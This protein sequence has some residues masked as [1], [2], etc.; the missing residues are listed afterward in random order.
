L[1]KEKRN[2]NCEEGYGQEGGEEAG[3]KEGSGEKGRGEKGSGQEGRCEE[4][5]GEK[6]RGEE[7][8]CKEGRQ[9]K[10]SCEKSGEEEGPC[11]KGCRQEGCEKTC[12]EES[13][14]EAG[15]K[16]GCGSGPGCDFDSNKD[17][18]QPTSC[19]A[20]PDGREALIGSIKTG[21]RLRPGF[22][23]AFSAVA[24][25]SGKPRPRLHTMGPAARV[26]LK[27][28]PR[29]LADPKPLVIRNLEMPPSRALF[30]SQLRSLPLVGR[31][32]VRDI[33]AV[34]S[35]RLLLVAS[36]RLSAFDV[37]MAEPIPGKGEV[38]TQTALFWF[39]RLAD[40]EPLDG[41][42]PGERRGRG[43]A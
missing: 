9:E 17:F 31:G 5:S 16:E 28:G 24:L 25:T 37:V 34:G 3:G 30:E 18:A 36:D 4:G 22:L 38:L 29:A 32:K 14:E 21:T 10:G 35:D 39:A 41:A 7:A 40:L 1:I 43:G 2:G 42:G 6:G 23:L 8:S 27:A 20:V 33:Y 12:R 15:C 13:S 11:E 19:L 26:C